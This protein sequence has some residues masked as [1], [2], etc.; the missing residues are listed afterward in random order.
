MKNIK[1]NVLLTKIL[2]DETFDKFTVINL[3]DKYLQH[4]QV[5]LCSI[6]AR[7]YVYKHILRLVKC[8]V[9]SKSGKKNSHKIMYKKTDL[10][11]EVNF[12]SGESSPPKKDSYKK[13]LLIPSEKILENSAIEKLKETLNEYKVDMMSA[14]GESEEYIRLLDSVPEMKEQ[15]SEKYHLARD[16]SSKLLGKIKAIQTIIA[17]QSEAQCN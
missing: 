8:G 9:L 4:S 11:N 10:F 3:R 7:K 5:S 13:P 15:L 14:I 6:E 1:M 12:I 2:E 17:I 16:K